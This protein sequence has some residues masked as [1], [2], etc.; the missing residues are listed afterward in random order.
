MREAAELVLGRA[1]QDGVGPVV[2]RRER[3]VGIR[4]LVADEPLPAPVPL[5]PPVEHAVD[6]PHLVLVP[7]NGRRQLLGV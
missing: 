6:P 7:L 2:P 4:Y 5:Q 1:L 3:E